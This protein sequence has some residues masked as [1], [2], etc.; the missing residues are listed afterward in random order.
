[1]G[2][3]L[4]YGQVIIL[5]ALNRS[6]LSARMGEC[7]LYFMRKINYCVMDWWTQWSV[8]IPS[9]G[10]IQSVTISMLVQ[11]QRFTGMVLLNI[12]KSVTLGKMFNSLLIM[13]EDSMQRSPKFL[14]AAFVFPHAKLMIH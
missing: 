3:G 2:V 7:T 14:L 8:L 12:L 11:V 13:M 5:L 6:I 4:Y 1:M 9:A 10:L